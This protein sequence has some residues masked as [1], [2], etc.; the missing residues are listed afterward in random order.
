MVV[1]N[2]GIARDLSGTH[3]KVR[4]NLPNILGIDFECDG[5]GDG[6]GDLTNDFCLDCGTSGESISINGCQE[7]SGVIGVSIIELSSKTDS[8][9]HP[10]VVEIEGRRET[11]ERRESLNDEALLSWYVD[12][13]DTRDPGGNVAVPGTAIG[14][15]D[16]GIRRKKLSQMFLTAPLAQTAKMR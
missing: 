5:D 12:A 14:I 10:M 9:D 11:E 15:G 3:P 6:D 7:D 2:D 8:S 4:T 13:N 1:G 16:E